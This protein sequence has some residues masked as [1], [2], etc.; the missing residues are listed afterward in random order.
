VAFFTDGAALTQAYPG[1]P[2]VI[3][4]PGEPQLA[5][6]TN[7]YCFLNRIEEAVEAY[8]Q[9]ARRWYGIPSLK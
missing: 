3:L 9:I 1:A 7:E 6:Q 2:I 4:G 5:H 8:R